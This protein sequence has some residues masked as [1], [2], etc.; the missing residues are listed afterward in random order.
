MVC[1]G[2][3]T[4]ARPDMRSTKAPSAKCMRTAFR[5][6]KANPSLMLMTSTRSAPSV[7][8]EPTMNTPRT[9]AK[10]TGW[11][12]GDTNS[13]GNGSSTS[14]Y[15]T[16]RAYQAMCEDFAFAQQSLKTVLNDY[17]DLFRKRFSEG[18][19]IRKAAEPRRNRASA[20]R[21]L[22][23][24]CPAFAA[25]GRGRWCLSADAEN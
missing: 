7:A 10:I 23:D 12:C 13:S 3:N 18:L 25:A 4:P 15:P 9:S 21:T 22:S 17:A 20:G 11:T 16:A 24:V 6:P 5:S 19:S 14:A 2:I 1:R 8:A